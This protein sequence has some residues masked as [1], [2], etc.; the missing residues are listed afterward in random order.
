MVG[1]EDRVFGS[2]TTQTISELL[3]EKRFT[4]DRHKIVLET[5]IKTLGVY[6]VPIKISSDVTASLKVWVVKKQPT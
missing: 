2:V 3:L 5:P 1:E 4:I 6:T